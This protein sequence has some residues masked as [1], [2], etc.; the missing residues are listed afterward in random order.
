MMAEGWDDAHMSSVQVGVIF[1]PINCFVCGSGKVRGL[2]VLWLL[3]WPVLL[4]VVLGSSAGSWGCPALH[5]DGCSGSQ[6]ATSF[7]STWFE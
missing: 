1:F 4:L 7:T 2:S 5:K 3:H 6:C